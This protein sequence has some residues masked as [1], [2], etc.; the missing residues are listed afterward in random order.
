MRGFYRYGIAALM[1]MVLVAEPVRAETIVFRAEL[2]ASSQTPPTNSK[3]TGTVSATYDT[4]TKVLSWKGTHSGLT[5][6]VTSAHVHGPAHAGKY[7]DVVIWISTKGMPLPASFEG[8]VTLTDAQVADM[9]AGLWY[10]NLH[11]AAYPPGEIRGQLEQ[12]K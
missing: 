12:V 9:M 10:V 5:G 2:K 7:A 4:N 3:G 6:P 8:Q 1:T 11:T